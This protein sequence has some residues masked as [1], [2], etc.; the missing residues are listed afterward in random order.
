M[1]KYL[2]WRWVLFVALFPLVV[3][4]LF[5]LV[6]WTYKAV[7][8]DPAYF[9]PPYIER[10]STPGGTA[11]AL[12][13]ALKVND[14][15]ALA[16]LQGWRHPAHLETGEDIIFVMLWE[17][18]EPYISYLYLNMDD[19]HRYTYYFEQLDGRWVVSPPDIC[20]YLGSG[21]WLVVAMPLAIIWWLV[22]AMVLLVQLV[23]RLSARLRELQLG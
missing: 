6:A 12:E 9:E 8:Y 14:Q 23:F 3:V 22:G 1:K 5:V 19:Y 7:R 16:E 21:R 17:V 11:L 18:D 2:D 13:Q 15:T 20:Y 10:Y 4:L